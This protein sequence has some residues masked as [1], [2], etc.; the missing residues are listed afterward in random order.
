MENKIKEIIEAKGLTQKELA[1][2]TGMSE[3]GISKAI[4]GSATR[5]TLKKI[6]DALDV[7]VDD[8]VEMEDIPVAKYDSGK[9]PLMLGKIEMPCYVLDDGRRVFSGRGIQKAIGSGNSSGQWLS[10]FINKGPL[11]QDFQLDKITER[12]NSP[13]RFKRNTAG[14]S[15][16]ITYGYEVTLLIDIC[17]AIIDANRVGRFNDESIVRNADIIIRAVAKVGIIAL[18]DE[19]TGYAKDKKRAKDELQR[20]LSSFLED[21]AQVW[22]K[23]FNDQFFEDLYK[24][25]HWNWTKTAKHPG[26][27]GMWINDIVYERIA[28]SILAE[29]QK[30][31]PKNDKGYRKWKHHQLLTEDVGKPKLLQHLE[32][33]HALAIAAQF[34]WARFM[35]FVDSAYP[36]QQQ[37]LSLLF[38]E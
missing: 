31:N 38:D 26:V 12:I 14:G 33:L 7:D 2:M 3:M 11:A 16:P 22:V 10:T 29:L 37:Q 18:V 17:S 34:D 23:T 25:R 32:A 19:A 30:R 36:K 21:E 9:T 8:L 6:A 15:Q 13:I 5:Q 1:S 24:M 20:F 4:K 28:P 27:V 35:S